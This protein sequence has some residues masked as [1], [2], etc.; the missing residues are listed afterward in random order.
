MPDVSGHCFYFGTFNP[1]HTGHLM[2]AQAALSQF[3]FERITFMPAGNPPHRHHENDLLEADL[4]LTMVRLATAQNPAFAVSDFERN[5]PRK[6]YTVQTLLLMEQ[7]NLISLPVPFIIGSDAL[8]NLAEWHQPAALIDRVHFLQAPR[9]GHDWVT[10]VFIDGQ[11]RP[12]N[13]SRIEM[14]P[15]GISATHIRH[16]LGQS[17]PATESL[18]YYLPEPVRQFIRWNRLYATSKNLP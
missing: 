12:L 16:M 1:I 10:H 11:K 14:P 15:L 4:R 2:I 13:T 5:L 6:S 7:A 9:P 18:R 17:P 3:G 8:S